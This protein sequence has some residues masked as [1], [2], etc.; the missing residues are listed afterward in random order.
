MESHPFCWAR[1]SS[2]KGL[3]WALAGLAVLAMVALQILDGPPKTDA[4]PAG[5][6]S[7]ELA[8]NLSNSEKILN[9][10]GPSA[11]VY[12]GL[13][14]GLDFLFIAAYVSASGL[15][16]ALVG[17]MLAA[18][19]RPADAFGLAMAGGMLLAGLL[20]CT[21]NYALIRLLL[22]SQNAALS[23]L[24]RMCALPKFL[25]VLLG[26]LFLAAGAIVSPFPGRHGHA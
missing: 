6:V 25:I 22:G 2:R 12:A 7:F 19:Y 9:S 18:R 23:S 15:G 14:R 4:S 20:D 1:E 8:G 24:V 17:M 3:F 5:I 16:C 21:E 10:W 11:G 26:L 13:Y